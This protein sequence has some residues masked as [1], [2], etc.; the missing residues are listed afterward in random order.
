MLWR[1]PR[2]LRCAVHET[3]I[4]ETG[5]AY[6]FFVGNLLKTIAL[7]IVARDGRIALWSKLGKEISRIREGQNWLTKCPNVGLI[8]G[9][10][11]T[12]ESGQQ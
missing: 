7:K 1:V 9:R 5:I 10:V 6:K 2:R 12:S 4:G 11:G 3:R 8:T